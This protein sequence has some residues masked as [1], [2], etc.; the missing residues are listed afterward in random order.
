M[1]VSSCSADRLGITLV[2]EEALGFQMLYGMIVREVHPRLRDMTRSI[3]I[4]A[5][6]LSRG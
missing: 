1:E 2:F 3:G 4:P 6:S 5:A